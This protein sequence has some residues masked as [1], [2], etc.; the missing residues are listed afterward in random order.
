M[1]PSRKAPPRHL[2]LRRGVA[3]LASEHETRIERG[4]CGAR[5]AQQLSDELAHSQVAFAIEVTRRERK[6]RLGNRLQLAQWRERSFER[7]VGRLAQWLSETI[8]GLPW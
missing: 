4:I 7:V 5:L 1:R 6:A 3:L 2:D 8:T